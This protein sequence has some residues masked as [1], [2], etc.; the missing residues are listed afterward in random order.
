VVS[1]TIN[2]KKADSITIM[3]NQ[4]TACFSGVPV[5]GPF[6]LTAVGDSGNT[7][8]HTDITV[9]SNPPPQNCLCV[10][11]KQ[12]EGSYK[13][14]KMV[15]AIEFKGDRP[16]DLEGKPAPLSLS[17]MVPAAFAV[18]GRSPPLPG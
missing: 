1:C 16:R 5:G 18:G 3:G 9:S 14:A 13:A 7:D 17:G 10:T 4:F 6:T 12:T 15:E 8:D 2:G 11:L